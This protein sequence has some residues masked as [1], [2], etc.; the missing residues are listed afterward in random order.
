MLIIFQK[1]HVLKCLF[2]IHHNSLLTIKNVIFINEQDTYFLVIFNIMEHPR[3]K[4]VLLIMRNVCHESPC[5]KS[6][7]LY[8]NDKN[9]RININL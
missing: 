7:P 5:V 6:L 4:L 9:E 2:L 8:I 1:Q 3:D